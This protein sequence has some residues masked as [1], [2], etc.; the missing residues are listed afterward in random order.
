MTFIS[1]THGRL[2]SLTPVQQ[3]YLVVAIGL[4]AQYLLSTLAYLKLLPVVAGVDLAGVTKNSTYMIPGI[5]AIVG[6]F[7]FEG[8]GGLK[9][10]FAPYRIF[11]VKPF[12]WVIAA[13]LL[14]P[15]LFFALLLDDLIYGRGLNLYVMTLPTGEEIM[16][17]A[18]MFLKVAICD[19]LF[20]IGFVYPRLLNAGFSPLK[21][22]LAIGL[23]WGADYIPF[24]F[25][26]FFIASG[27]N[28]PNILLGWFSLTPIY[29]WLYHRTGSAIVVLVF[30]VFMQFLFTAVPILPQSTG[31][32][33]GVAM[34]NVV[35]LAVGLFL[36]WYAPEGKKDIVVFKG[37]PDR[38]EEAVRP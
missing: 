38:A 13:F 21:A 25:T 7:F 24:F 3:A 1:N 35:C 11:A 20:W 8:K 36:W 17:Y 27:L 26:Q 28:M 33:A 30:N 31:D 23:F 37:G 22:S 16:G 34:A 32:N 5:L 18:P 29:I 10:I 19:E 14:I 2:T 4:G 12:Y 9:R 6:T 15:I